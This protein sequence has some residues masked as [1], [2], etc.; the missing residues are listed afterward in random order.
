M[1]KQHGGYVNMQNISIL[2]A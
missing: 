2:T 1:K